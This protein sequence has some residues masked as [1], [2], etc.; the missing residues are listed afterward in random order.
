MKQKNL[1]LRWLYKIDLGGIWALGV[2]LEGIVTHIGFLS[3]ILEVIDGAVTSI[4]V[5]SG[6]VL[7]IVAVVAVIGER[8]VNGIAFLTVTRET[9]PDHVCARAVVFELVRGSIGVFYL[10]FYSS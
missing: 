2:A 8:V 7:W 4:T 3:V 10:Y 9:R 1:T 6:I 5:A